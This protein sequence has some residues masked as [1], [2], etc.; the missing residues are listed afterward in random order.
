MPPHPLSNFLI[1][2]YCQNKSRF[3]GVYSHD[4]LPNELKDGPYVI[5]LDRYADVGPHGIA[6]YVLDTDATYFD[7]FGVE[8]IFKEIR[9]FIGNNNMQTNIFR[10]Q[11]YD[12]IMCGYFCSGFIDYMIAGKTL[13]DYTCLFLPHDFKK[14]DKVILGYM[15]NG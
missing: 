3:N 2:R 13:I 9:H 14:N 7:R 6:L 8:Y 10:T 11:A 5:N 1:Q 15:K 4:N 12:S